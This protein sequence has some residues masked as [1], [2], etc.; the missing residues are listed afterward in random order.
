M[1]AGIRNRDHDP[2]L[3]DPPVNIGPATMTF[4]YDGAA[5]TLAQTYG[6]AS[7]S[8]LRFTTTPSA[9]TATAGSSGAS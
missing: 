6:S 1:T 7:G 9:V 4:T 5:F 8:G 2:M 3:V